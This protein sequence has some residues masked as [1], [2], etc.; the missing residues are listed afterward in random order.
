MIT[1]SNLYDKLK[2]T[3]SNFSDATAF[4]AAILCAIQGGI[5]HIFIDAHVKGSPLRI[6]GAV[7]SI[8]SFLI[9]LNRWKRFNIPFRIL[10][11]PV[12]LIASRGIMGFFYWLCSIPGFGHCILC[13]VLRNL[14]IY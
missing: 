13:D 8:L 2:K 14:F 9:I 3:V 1:L 6:V 12:L 5:T 10:S 4:L 11:F 7:W